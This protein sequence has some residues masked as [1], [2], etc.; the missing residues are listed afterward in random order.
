TWT[1]W[2]YLG[3]A[4]IGKAVR[5]DKDDPL[6]G[7]GAWSLMPPDGSPFPWRTANDADFDITGRMTPQGAY[8]S[9]V[10]GKTETYLYSRE[11]EE[12]GKTE[13]ITPWG[14]P[15][16]VSSWNHAGYEGKPVEVMAFSGA[17]EVELFLNGQS[18]SRKPVPRDGSMP[19]S[20][21]FET[22]YQPGKL[23]AVSY[24]GGREVSRG[25]LETTGKPVQLR[26]TAE[27]TELRADGHDLACVEMELVDAEGRVV[28]DAEI[29]LC[30][31]VT[32]Q[33]WLA[34][35]GTANPMTAEDYT[36]GETVSWR[37][38][39]LAIIRSG[40]ESGE[41]S[42]TVSADGLAGENIRLYAAD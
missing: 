12:F 42:L 2:D 24:T 34:G 33:G 27:K 28:P 7:K 18:I 35:F 39:A 20:V 26:L 8:R 19:R 21:E 14:F 1:A 40:Y 41:I 10:W 15:V 30:A 31:E 6:I 36:D 38:R 37:G 25:V 4:G 32:G 9:V 17:E 11:P 29:R 5:V 22:A 23:E 13:M 3:E 16:L